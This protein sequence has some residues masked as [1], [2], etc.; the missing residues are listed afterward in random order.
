M[1]LIC[2][3]GLCFAG[4][5]VLSRDQLTALINARMPGYGRRAGK[6]FRELDRILYTMTTLNELLRR[7]L[8]IIVA[9]AD[10]EGATV[11]VHDEENRAPSI[12]AS[13]PAGVQRPS[14]DGCLPAGI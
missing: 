13:F 8:V 2:I 3:C 12:L 11:C 1:L 4:V 6:V 10:L 14:C 7:C 5:C 9:S